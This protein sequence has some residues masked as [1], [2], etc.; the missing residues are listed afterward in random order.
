LA[1]DVGWRDR[2]DG[3][4]WL[5]SYDLMAE[6]NPLLSILHRFSAA[7]FSL[8]MFVLTFHR[9]C[10]GRTIGQLYTGNCGRHSRAGWHAGRAV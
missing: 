2:H 9:S 5:L 4:R 10:L 1:A 7:V 8:S 6:S 3:F